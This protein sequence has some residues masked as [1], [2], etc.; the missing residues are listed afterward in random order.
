MSRASRLFNSARRKIKRATKKREKAVKAAN[1]GNTNRAES[2]T[3][4]AERLENKASQFNAALSNSIVTGLVGKVVNKNPLG[5]T[6]I[7]ASWNHPSSTYEP[8]EKLQLS[9]APTSPFRSTSWRAVADLDIGARQHDFGPTKNLAYTLKLFGLRG[10]S[11]TVI[12][13]AHVPK[14]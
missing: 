10:D 8:Y 2:L 4:R 9:I 5:N 6:V 13:R 14:A 11:Q 3:A 1:K 7:R 12:D